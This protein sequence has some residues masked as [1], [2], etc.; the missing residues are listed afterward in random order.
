MVPYVDTYLN[1]R[2]ILFPLTPSSNISSCDLLLRVHRLDQISK[3]ASGTVYLSTVGNHEADSPGT[4]SLSTYTAD[5]SGGECDVMALGLLPEPAPATA[6][7]PW[8]SYDVGIIHFVGMS[9]EHNFSRGTQQ[10]AWIEADLKAVDRTVTP[11][12]I[13]GGH[14]AMYLNSD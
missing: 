9:T 14:R 2:H 6:D 7:E 13:F 11:W 3:V 1:S 4:A 8:W 5:G 12:I 10:Y